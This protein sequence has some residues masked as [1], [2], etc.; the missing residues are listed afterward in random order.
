MRPTQHRSW[1]GSGRSG[2]SVARALLELRPRRTR[3]LVSTLALYLLWKTQDHIL[4]RTEAEYPP[5]RPPS[6][7]TLFFKEYYQ[8]NKNS[9]MGADGK[10]DVTDIA[11][12][13]GQQWSELP[14]TDARKLESLNARAK[15][16]GQAYEK[17]YKE[18]FFA[19]TL[20]ERNAVE[21]ALGRKLHFPGGKGDFKKELRERPG[22]PGRPAS[23]FFEFSR[24]LQD[25]LKQHP[26]IAG[27]TGM[28]LHQSMARIAAERWRELSAEDKEVSE[29]KSWGMAGGGDG[30]CLGVVRH[31]DAQHWKQEYLKRKAKFDEWFK[32]QKES[33][34]QK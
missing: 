31:T 25:E 12:R 26:E 27:K 19:R 3:F 9:L 2:P 11:R 33:G 17:E 32:T 29:D 1:T 7:Y 13:V 8:E 4:T 15:E 21:K 23:S 30:G 22:N 16:L 5:K 24:S 18:W 14:S 10:Y 6:A 20:Q 34:P 28:D